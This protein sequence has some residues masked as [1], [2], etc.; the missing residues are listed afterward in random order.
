ML[1]FDVLFWGK[2]TAWFWTTVSDHLKTQHMNSGCW[3]EFSIRSWLLVSRTLTVDQE[4][5]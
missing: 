2:V 3:L 5:T 4:C 1:L